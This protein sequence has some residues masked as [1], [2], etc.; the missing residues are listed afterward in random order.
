MP[1]PRVSVVIPIYDRGAY[2]KE[3]VD[4]ILA[5][6]FADLEV[7]VVDDGSTDQG[8]DV[9]RAYRDSRVRLVCH[10]RNRGIAAGRNT[11][12]DAAR[13]EYLAFLDSDDVAYPNRL[14]RQVEFLDD[15]P[16]YGGVGA[17][18]DWMDA[19]G[20]PLRRVKRRPLD[21]A[22]IAALRL[23]RQGIENTASMAPTAVLREYRHDESYVVSEDF[24]LWAR[25]AADR[26]LA[27][28][29][30][31]LVRR[32]QHPRQTSR[33]EGDRTPRLRQAIY[34]R[35][36]TALGIEFG[37][38]DLRRHLLLRSMRKSGFVPDQSYLEWADR[39]LQSLR[40]AN[41]HSRLYPEPSFSRLLGA[42]WGQV[43]WRAAPA[44]GWWAAARAFRSSP[45]SRFSFAGLRSAAYLRVSRPSVWLPRR[46][47]IPLPA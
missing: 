6:T 26:P 3:A 41:L 47:G 20:R 10:G 25:I 13:G 15:H 39:W 11:G 37:E 7:I 5:Q 24:D 4:S 42:L 28:I 34:A 35:Q 2:I 23:F 14:A 33:R 36:L 18:I 29:P 31:I 27:N 40:G 1:D 38:E 30:E 19:S 22:D 16:G 12:I 8:P 44:L 21:P 17:W 45:L 32:R 46:L 43:C 9:V